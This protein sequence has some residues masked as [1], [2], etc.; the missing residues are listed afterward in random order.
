[1]N[2][3]EFKKICS[4]AILQNEPSLLEFAV[5]R[6][7]EYCFKESTDTTVDEETVDYLAATFRSAA[8]N[9]MDGSWHLLM[10]LEYNWSAFTEGQRVTLLEAIEFSFPRFA[11][12]MSWF[13]LSEVLGEYFCCDR[14]FE[15][16]T[17]FAHLPDDGPRSQVP[18]GL[19]HIAKSTT[20]PSLRTRCL[21]TIQRMQKDPSDV[22]REEVANSIEMLKRRGLM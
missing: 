9:Q 22:V 11:D 19:E 18:H 5:G 16:L 17:R 21:N 10:L 7:A 15:L 1:M 13:V 2:V 14:A 20:D 6:F 3:L 8:F 4:E 12:P